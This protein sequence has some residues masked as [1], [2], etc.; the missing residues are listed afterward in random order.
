MC[1]VRTD[2]LQQ[3]LVNFVGDLY[4]VRINAVLPINARAVVGHA[5]RLTSL[6]RSGVADLVAER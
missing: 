1:D 5:D 4:F 3:F 6:D 2:D